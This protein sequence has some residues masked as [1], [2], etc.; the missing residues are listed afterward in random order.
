[1]IQSDDSKYF[2]FLSVF[3]KRSKQAETV[4]SQQ[5][6]ITASLVMMYERRGRE[7]DVVVVARVRGGVNTKNNKGKRV[8]RGCHFDE[9]PR[10]SNRPCVRNA[11]SRVQTGSRWHAIGS[12]T[13]QHG[14]VLLKNSFLILIFIL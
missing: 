6:V 12:T 13:Q 7:G 2:D 9:T 14:I 4:K 5:S 11:G 8:G 3:V 10:G 1:M